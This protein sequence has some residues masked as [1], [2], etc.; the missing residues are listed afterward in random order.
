MEEFKELITRQAPYQAE[1]HPQRGILQEPAQ[2]LCHELNHLSPDNRQRYGQIIQELFAEAGQAVVR[3]GFHCDYGFNIHF[4]GFALVNFGC[5]FLDTSPI[6]IGH[7]VFIA[8]NVTISCAG[9]A[10]HPKER[11]EGV[12]TS[13]PITI[14]DGVWIG[15]GAVICPGVTIHE[16]AVIGA[17]SV[18]NKD[19]PAGVIAAGVPCRVIREITEEDLIRKDAETARF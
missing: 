14:E 8:P 15:A 3:P 12:S 7:M 16:G 13:A 2:R 11:M 17:G 6:H 19:I 9:H 1:Y 5:S 18:V 4:L 10:I